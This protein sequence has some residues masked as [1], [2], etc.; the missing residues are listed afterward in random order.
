MIQGNA[1]TGKTLLALDFALKKANDG[2]KVLYLAY[3]KNLV[4]NLKRNL[5]DTKPT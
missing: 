2:M 5:G 3:N 1:G 4:N